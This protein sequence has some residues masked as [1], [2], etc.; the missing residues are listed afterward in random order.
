MTTETMANPAYCE[1]TTIHEGT[2]RSR[3]RTSIAFGVRANQV[4][5]WSSTNANAT[6]L[7]ITTA[8]LAAKSRKS[9]YAASLRTLD[10]IKMSRKSTH[11]PMKRLLSS[12]ITKTKYDRFLSHHHLET[13]RR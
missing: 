1:A 2:A 3:S 6:T 9:S 12:R 13:G 10:P 8:G 5:T 11:H 7:R 4:T